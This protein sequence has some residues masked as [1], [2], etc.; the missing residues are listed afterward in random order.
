MILTFCTYG[1]AAEYKVTSDSLNVR[2]CA[3]TQCDI[4]SSLKRDEKVQGQLSSNN[5]IEIMVDGKVGYVSAR[6]LEQISD[7]P[8]KRNYFKDKSLVAGFLG[9]VAVFLLW[10]FFGGTC[11]KCKKAHAVKKISEKCVGKE[12]THI[13]K[14]FETKNKK[15]E[16]IRTTERPVLA[17][18]FYYEEL[19]QCKRCGHTYTK[20]RDEIKEK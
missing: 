20:T 15:G 5:W 2:S 6:Y 3:S 14:K 1:Y 11:P 7:T 4:I 13:T 12:N 18:K 17:T 8:N 9:I 10:V 19:Y 16:V